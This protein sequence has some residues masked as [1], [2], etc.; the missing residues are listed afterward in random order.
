MA[1][2]QLANLDYFQIKNALRDYLRANSDFSDYDFEGSTLGMLLD[3]LAYNTYYTAFNAN[4]VVNESF[5]DSATVRDNIVSIAKQLGY[6]PRSANSP[7]AVVNINA[8]LSNSTELPSTVYLRR[9]NAC[10][11]IINDQMYQYV[12][13][14]DVPGTVQV[15][16]TVTFQN[17]KIYEGSFITNRYSVVDDKQF[18]IILQNQSID[19]TTIRAHVFESSTSSNFRKYLPSD[20][21]LNV[22]SDSLVYFI[23]EVEDENYKVTFGDGVFGRK[24]NVGEVVELSYITTNGP[25]TNSASSFTYNGIISDVNGS[26]NFRVSIN[27]LTTV[28]KSFGGS[29]IESIESIKRNAPA[30]YGSQNRAVT[31]S[32][33]D[34]IIRRIYPAAADIITFGGE[35]ADPPEYGKVKISIKPRNV[36]YLSQY[37]KKLIV[38]ELRKFSVGSV[39]PEIIDSSIIFIELYSNIYYNQSETTLSASDIKTKIISNIENYIEKSDT[40]KFGGKF[41]YSKYIGVIDSSEKSIRSNLTSILMRKD[42]Y[43]SLNNNAYYELCFNNPFDDDIDS[44]TLTSTGFT[45]QQYPK[46]TVYLEDRDEKIIL[47]RL[48]QQTGNKI[49]LNNNQGLINYKRGEVQLYNLNIIKGSF[50]DNKIE[51]RLKPQYNDILAKRETY[52]DVDVDKSIFTLIQE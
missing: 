50:S 2:N 20:N 41:R 24:L 5:L 9:G 12:V 16:G 31:A 23:S 3:V 43:P 39:T 42:F 25:E 27:A 47:Y 45:V 10:L 13:L 6:T 49:V 28:S 15:D 37:S 35:E 26:S 38:D 22:K 4:M 8:T 18:N 21:I 34:A 7:V 19:T 52:L 36:S 1:Y 32:D 30:L 14:E 11:T 51:V 40:E 46:N 48:D 33:Y 44:L 29:I 17:V